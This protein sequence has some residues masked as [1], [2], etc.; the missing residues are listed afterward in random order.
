V[1]INYNCM[2]ARKKMGDREINKHQTVRPTAMIR[3]RG[4]VSSPSLQKSVSEL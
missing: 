3:I 2:N 4:R 1:P